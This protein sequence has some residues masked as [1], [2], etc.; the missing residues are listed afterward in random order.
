MLNHNDSHYIP[1]LM[2]TLEITG[3]EVSSGILVKSGKIAGESPI[4]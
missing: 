4:W 2:K 1:G 3:L